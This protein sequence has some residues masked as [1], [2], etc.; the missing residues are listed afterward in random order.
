MWIKD[1]EGSYVNLD[2]I[3]EIYVQKGHTLKKV[4]KLEKRVLEFEVVGEGKNIFKS[5]GIFNTKQK[6]KKHIKQVLKIN[7]K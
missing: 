3:H 7:G 6:A 5:L 2:H 1:A 4:D